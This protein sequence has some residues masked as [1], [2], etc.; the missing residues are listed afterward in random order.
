MLRE[1]GIVATDCVRS[2][3]FACIDAELAT[4]NTQQSDAIVTGVQNAQ[5]SQPPSPQEVDASSNMLS[6]KKDLRRILLETIGMH[7]T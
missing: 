6:L 5:C 1:E 2:V 4:Q 7:S 3:L